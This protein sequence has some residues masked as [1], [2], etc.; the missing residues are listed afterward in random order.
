[1]SDR[2]NL[3]LR[4]R[5]IR[6]RSIALLLLGIVLLLPPAANMALIDAQ[7]GDLPFALA[8]VFAVWVFLI[9]GTALLSRPLL[10]SDDSSKTPEN[11]SP[12][13]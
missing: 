7:V 10:A 3:Q 6:D 13:N 4:R 9:I 2:A 5:K 11:I 12:E 1:M 8:Y